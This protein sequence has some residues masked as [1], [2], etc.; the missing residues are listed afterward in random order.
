MIGASFQS[1]VADTANLRASASKLFQDVY[2]TT[3]DPAVMAPAADHYDP[4]HMAPAGAPAADH[5]DPG[6]M[7]PAG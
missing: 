3:Y 1:G 2:P 7:A 5:Y 4:G 6:H